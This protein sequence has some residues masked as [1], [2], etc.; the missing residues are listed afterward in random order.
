R[1]I[2]EVNR[3]L[4]PF[5]SETYEVIAELGSGS[6]SQVGF[7]VR[8]GVSKQTCVGYDAKKS[9]LFIDRTN[10]GQVGFSKDFPGRHSGPAQSG[11]R[12]QVHLFV[13]RSSIELFGNAGTTVISDRIFPPADANG[14]QLFAY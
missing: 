10:S 7:D 14:L 6:G 3:L 5:H 12:V 9:E 11:K 1:G 2:A 8:K 4:R 13:D